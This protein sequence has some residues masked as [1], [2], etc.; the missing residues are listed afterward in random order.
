MGVGSGAWGNDFAN[1]VIFPW[2][3][4]VM[5]SIN[6]D[7]LTYYL[8]RA[9]LQMA[10]FETLNSFKD[11]YDFKESQIKRPNGQGFGIASPLLK[12]PFLASLLDYTC[13]TSMLSIWGKG[14]PSS[15]NVA[16]MWL[17][18]PIGKF[19]RIHIALIILLLQFC[20]ITQGRVKICSQFRCHRNSPQL[21]A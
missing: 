21:A 3:F 12:L 17:K 11:G 9:S 1:N 8:P 4:D 13:G 10:T 5:K 15:G 20:Q 7:V 19:V 16:T 14:R 6:Q 18:S 2:G